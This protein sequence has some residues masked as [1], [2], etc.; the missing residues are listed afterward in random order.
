MAFSLERQRWE[1]L[2]NGQ[3]WETAETPP[4]AE[5]A[6]PQE[7]LPPPQNAEPQLEDALEVLLLQRQVHLHQ[8]YGRWLRGAFADLAARSVR[9]EGL[10]RC[11]WAWLGCAWIGEAWSRRR[12]VRAEAHWHADEDWHADE[13]GYAEGV[14]VLRAEAPVFT[15]GQPPWTQEHADA[16]Q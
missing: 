5:E 3:R 9:R 6:G 2:P 7:S 10:I 11:L 1:L 4:L 14:A 8:V 13:G 16:F 15:P 12:G